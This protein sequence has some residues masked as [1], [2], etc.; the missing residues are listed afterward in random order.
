MH[1]YNI[2]DKITVYF[3]QNTIQ[4]NILYTVFK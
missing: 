3:A 2:H 4:Q 1:M